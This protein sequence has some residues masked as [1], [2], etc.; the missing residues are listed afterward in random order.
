LAA[1]VMSE[2]VRN[3]RPS[4]SCEVSQR[5]AMAMGRRPVNRK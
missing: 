3:T 2:T 1:L 5:A 4:V